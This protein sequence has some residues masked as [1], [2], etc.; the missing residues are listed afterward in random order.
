MLT[1]ADAAALT[2]SVRE[3]LTNVVRHSGVNE[4][5]VSVTAD[6]EKVVVEV[7]DDGCG[8]DPAEPRAAGHYGLIGMRERVERL[9]GEMK[10]ES[11]HGQGTT[12]RL[13]IPKT[14]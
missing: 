13:R 5:T 4:A 6:D 12:V 2:G 7:R 11:S 1:A 3:A 8:F 10:I 14:A 9:G